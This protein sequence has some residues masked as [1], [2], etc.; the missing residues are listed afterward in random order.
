VRTNNPADRDKHG[1]FRSVGGSWVSPHEDS[2]YA[3]T[4]TQL[5]L[6]KGGP[7]HGIG[8]RVYIHHRMDTR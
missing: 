8:F 7:N 4:P 2:C 6:T 1:Y 3:K 5:G